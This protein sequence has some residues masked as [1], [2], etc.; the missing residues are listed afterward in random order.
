MNPASA[1]P[2]RSASSTAVSPCAVSPCLPTSRS[3][4]VT[5]SV[6]SGTPAALSAAKGMMY[7]CGESTVPAATR[8]CARSATDVMPAS[9]RTTTY[10]VKSRSESRMPRARMGAGSREQ[11]RNRRAC[12]S[13]EFQAMC[14]KRAKS[15]VF[16]RS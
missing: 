8:R 3:K 5:V 13:G 15:A 12:E 2:E 16:S 9:S 1:A 7:A 10:D 14:T 11:A 6:E 4:R